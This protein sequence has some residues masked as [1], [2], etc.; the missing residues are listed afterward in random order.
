MLKKSPSDKINSAKNDHF[1]LSRA[2][3]HHSFTFNFQFFYETKQKIRLFE[4]LMGFSIL[5]F[6]SFLS[7]F[8]F[9]FNKMHGLFNFKTS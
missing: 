9:L 5:D 8:I 3:T 6:V 2:P 1:F 7:K 4:T